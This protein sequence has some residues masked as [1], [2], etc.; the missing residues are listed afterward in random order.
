MA[1]CPHCNCDRPIQR[2]T[3]EGA[4]PICSIGLLIGNSS[5]EHG[6]LCRGPIIGALDVCTF[7]NSP[8]FAKAKSLKEYSELENNETLMRQKIAEVQVSPVSQFNSP[9]LV[10][11]IVLGGT[12]GYLYFGLPG[13]ILGLILGGIIGVVGAQ[14]NPKS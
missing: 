14:L 10:A 12:I 2:Q 5:F 6:Q 1:W 4:C 8:I 3:Y 9:L 13:F 7:C 11:W